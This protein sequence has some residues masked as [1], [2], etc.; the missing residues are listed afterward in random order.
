ME[1][2]Y[3]YKIIFSTSNN[4]SGI[5]INREEGVVIVCAASIA[6]MPPS[7]VKAFNTGWLVVTELYDITMNLWCH[8][9]D[10]M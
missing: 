3:C 2:V 9:N 5:K 4:L 8:S 6:D 10:I 7:P 1:E